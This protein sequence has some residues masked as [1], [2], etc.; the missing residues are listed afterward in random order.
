MPR[1]RFPVFGLAWPQALLFAL[2]LGPHPQRKLTLM[3]RFRLACLGSAWPQA[4]PLLTYLPHLPYLPY[5]PNG[6]SRAAL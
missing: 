1:L 6:Q 5:P 2:A 3:P 4:L